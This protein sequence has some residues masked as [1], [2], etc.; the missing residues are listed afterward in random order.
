MILEKA[1]LGIIEEGKKIGEQHEAEKMAEM[2]KAKKS[3][4]MKEIWKI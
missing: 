4:G 3:S 2:L 1:A